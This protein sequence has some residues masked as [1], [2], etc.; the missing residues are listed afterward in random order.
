MPQPIQVDA[1][2]RL[3]FSLSWLPL[4]HPNH[5]GAMARRQA[6][7]ARS[8]ARRR[9]A[10]TLSRKKTLADATKRGAPARTHPSRCSRLGDWLLLVDSASTLAER[11]HTRSSPSGQGH[12][13]LVAH[14][15]GPNS[16]RRHDGHLSCSNVLAT[17]RSQP[18]LD[19]A[20]QAPHPSSPH[21]HA[22][23]GR[24]L[25]RAE[26]LGTRS[27]SHLAPQQG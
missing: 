1:S 25:R 23:L 6:R 17:G 16:R 10:G 22:N 12:Q 11:R 14:V 20:H 3:R 24:V 15:S 9:V 4:R 19:A 27:P 18:H 8:H 7:A 26:R 5:D 13:A 2:S 21:H